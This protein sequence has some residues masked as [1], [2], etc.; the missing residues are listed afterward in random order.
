MTFL[1]MLESRQKKSKSLLCIGLDPSKDKM[2]QAILKTRNP[3]FEFNKRIIVSTHS[4]VCSYKPQVAYYNA[5]GAEAE[6]E[7]TI[8]YIKQN[9]SDIPIILDA[10]RSDIGPIAK[11]YALESFSRYKVDAV[12][13]NPFL[14]FDSIKPFTDWKDK[15]TIILCKTSNPSSSDIQDIVVNGKPFFLNLAEKA[16]KE[17]NYNKNV[18]LV[19]GAT[20]PSEMRAI[21]QIAPDTTFL[22]PGIGAQGG[23]IT[24]VMENG[25]RADGLGL[26]ISS[27]RAII[28]ASQEESFAE[29]A[30]E[31]AERYF[32]E[33][34]DN[35]KN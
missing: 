13:V 3:I 20:F 16:I 21:R 28:H 11:M 35:W 25:L 24:E 7:M 10:K 29:K 15:G 32:Q 18:L 27:S 17:W 31:I 22:V 30:R 5:I 6:L 26:I 8:D 12:T 4:L 23:S 19:V 14:G 1:E 34:Y 9:F 33:I 2:P